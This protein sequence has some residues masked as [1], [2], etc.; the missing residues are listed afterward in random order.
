MSSDKNKIQIARDLAQKV[1]LG[2]YRMSGEGYFDHVTR[3]MD[4][5]VNIMVTD[6][7]ILCAA[8]LHHSLDLNNDYANEIKETLGEEVLRLVKEYQNVSRSGL[9][10]IDPNELNEKLIIQTYLNLTN[11]PKILLI[12]LADKVDNIKTCHQLPIDKARKVSERAIYIYSPICQLVGLNSFVKEL[13][14]EAFKILNPMEYYKIEEYK[15]ENLDQINEK[16]EEI[17]EFIKDILKDKNIPSEIDFRI[18]SNYSVFKKLQKYKK[19][20]EDREIESIYDIAAMRIIV[21]EVEECYESED[22]LKQIWDA[23]SD[24]RDDYIATPKPSG[25]RSLHNV[26]TIGDNLKMEVQ[27]K[28]KS[29]H[30]ENEYGVASHAFYKMNTSMRKSIETKPDLLKQ[31]SFDINNSDLKI[32]Q[33]TD[34]VYVFTPKGDIVELPRGANIIDFAYAIHKDIGNSCIGGFVNDEYQ[35]LTYEL[36]DGQK[37]EIKTSKSKKKPSRD[38]V[39]SVKTKRAKDEI[40]KALKEIVQF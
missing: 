23:D 30:N 34:K 21:G 3:V 6:E 33:F 2:Q 9:S 25:Y 1:H 29:M 5:L 19:K 14:N 10:N 35:K 39:D 7:E 20:D 8:L 12:R 32:N 4:N 26:F 22:I 18:K 37:V 16:L 27:I 38:W 28:T 13:E 36:Q 31:L 15:K 24:E 11:D 17:R 40:R